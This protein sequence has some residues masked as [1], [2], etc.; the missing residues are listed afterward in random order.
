MTSD[1]SCVLIAGPWEHRYV[2]AN[3]ARFHL[4]VAGEGPL[5]LFLHGFPQ[6]WWTWRH[7]LEAVAAAGY[8]AAAMDL[9]GYGASD[10]P[11]QGYDAGPMAADVAGV[12]RSLGEADAVVVGHDVGGALAWS[13]PNAH[14]EAV[15]AISVIGM[16]H[17]AGLTRLA[18]A[19]RGLTSLLSL[20][21]P[22][23]QER[24]LARGPAYVDR[25]LR[26]WAA[27]GATWPSWEEISRYAEAMTIPFVAHSALE[28]YR[29]VLRPPL[30]VLG[31]EE[32]RARRT[33]IAVP[34]LQ[35]QGEYDAT[36]PQAAFGRSGQWVRG[37]Y[38]RHI[39]A[40]A[41]H[42]PHEERPDE[43]SAH[44]ITWLES[45]GGLEAQGR[46]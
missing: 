23:R 9:R 28:S 4:A 27:P 13:L 37:A 31:R 39:I 24:E 41:G 7:Q 10:K 8:R 34:V 44:L 35:F 15:R 20:D 2:A 32:V 25:I 29:A 1:P 46:G 45:L 26:S 21:R 11:P 30:R 14:P 33:P 22:L 12:I 5:V 40:G 43:V 16:P 38:A 6:F 18:S 3:G 36:M 19:A 17:P 42:A